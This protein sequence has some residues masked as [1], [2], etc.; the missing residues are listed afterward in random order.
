MPTDNASIPRGVLV[1]Q[2]LWPLHTAFWWTVIGAGVWAWTVASHGLR[3]GGDTP[4]AAGRLQHTAELD[5]V[6]LQTLHPPGPPPS[7]AA[8]AI[9]AAIHDNA[10]AVAMTFNR[11][12]MDW[13]A[14]YRALAEG[15]RPPVDAGGS[16]VRDQL[17]APGPTWLM[18][19]A[20]TQVF[21]RR[22]AMVLGAWP[23]FALGAALG[24][25]D[26]L[27]ARA[28]RKACAGR[29][30]ASLYHRAKLGASFLAIL[31]YLAWLAWPA[32][33]HPSAVMPIAATVLALLLRLQLTYY[34]KYV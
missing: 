28:R 11:T 34:K 2:W 16:F 5:A 20:G 6:V 22:T 25:T 24:L 17:D 32:P 7:A 8:D 29:E 13:P 19:V 10:I 18:L 15:R 1:R 21:A 14:R 3:A 27:V 12:L 23:V 31:G 9:F 30:S 4:E 26:G 33:I